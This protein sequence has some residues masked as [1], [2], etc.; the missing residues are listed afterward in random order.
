MLT[1]HRLS[2]CSSLS[3]QLTQVGSRFAPKCPI[4]DMRM[5]LQASR[6]DHVPARILLDMHARARPR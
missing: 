3:S 5:T 6:R 4:R 1:G 2:M